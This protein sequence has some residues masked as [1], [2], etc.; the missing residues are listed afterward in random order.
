MSKTLADMD[1]T[2]ARR[3]LETC[4][5][6]AMYDYMAEFGDKYAILANGVAR[7]NSLTGN[8]ASRN[9]QAIAKKNGKSLTEED[10]DKIRFEMAN[11]YLTVRTD[12]SKDKDYTQLQ[13]KEAQEFHR[14]V[15][16]R[17]GLPEKSWTMEIPLNTFGDPKN[18]KIWNEMLDSA[19]NFLSEF[20]VSLKITGEMALAQQKLLQS[21]DPQSFRP[22]Y[23]REKI[24][25]FADI[26]EWIGNNA[27][28][29]EN[30]KEALERA[31]DAT[32]GTEK[33][34]AMPEKCSVPPQTNTIEPATETVPQTDAESTGEHNPQTITTGE[35]P[36]PAQDPRQRQAAMAEAF[37]K[38]PEQATQTYPELKSAH[39]ALDV[40][41]AYADKVVEIAQQKLAKQINTGLPIP[42]PAKVIRAAI[43]SISSTRELER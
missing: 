9:M 13:W 31:K 36:A 32:L 38:N 30:M 2:E 25:E 10:V 28:S 21:F 33:A 18:E 17:N 16:T 15:F 37:L 4:G 41:N 23:E 29:P 42:A 7:G 34:G 35:V 11:A 8:A 39:R 1:T 3:L 5:P 19:G 43:H 26:T 6:A 20:G 24:A 14:D 12:K 22:D 40:V 27:L